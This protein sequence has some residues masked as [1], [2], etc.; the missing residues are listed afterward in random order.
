MAA[1]RPAELLLISKEAASF[2]AALAAGSIDAVVV[3]AFKPLFELSPAPGT[4]AV[5]AL[6]R[7]KG[8]RVS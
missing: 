4:L 2:A 7:D 5:E 1:R 3:E 8:L 6:A